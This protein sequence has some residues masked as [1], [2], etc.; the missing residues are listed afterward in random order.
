MN[1]S[2]GVICLG[3]EIKNIT[4]NPG[5]L[6]SVL[7]PSRVVNGYHALT[8]HYDLTELIKK[9]QDLQ[10]T[11]SQTLL[12]IQE[13]RSEFEN[14][15]LLRNTINATIHTIERKLNNVHLPLSTRPR[16]TKRGLING[17]GSIIKFVT[18]NLDA[19]DEERY[20]KIINQIQT[21]QQDLQSQVQLQYSINEATQQNFNKTMATIAH[22]N[23]E[24][25]NELAFWKTQNPKYSRLN[26]ARSILEHQ[27]M[28]FNFL[29][30][31][32]QDIESSIVACRTG[33]LH[34][35]VISA[36]TLY[37]ELS[38][39]SFFY[40]DRFPDFENQN[41]FEVQSYLKV[42]CYITAEEIIYF[43]DIP[44]M[45]PN[46]YN[47]Y[48]LEPLPTSVR[49]EFMTIIPDVKYFISSNKL[50]I[51][52][53][54]KCPQIGHVYLCPNYLLSASRPE[55]EINFLTNSDTSKCKFVK[56]S[57]NDNS[58]TLMLEINRYLLFFPRG[59]TISITQNEEIETRTLYGIYLASPGKQNLVYR[60]RTLFAP[61]NELA[62]KPFI[63][64]DVFPNLR[65]AQL[66]DRE[67]D[68]KELELNS[69]TLHDFRPIPSSGM[70]KFIQPSVWTILLYVLIVNL[71]LYITY[72]YFKAT[73]A[74]LNVT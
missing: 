12:N 74:V 20:D 71:M 40:K 37:Q 26:E 39:L 24:I 15:E 54:Q 14:T 3:S 61:R 58:V 13:D 18:G 51:P 44:L 55:C 50:A 68:L 32:I 64:G 16:K 73:R 34:P 57:T 9:T 7:G 62:G 47:M 8:H 6:S 69:L 4:T 52:L 42:K 11:Y 2:V 21:S 41:L 31:V 38:R 60:N 30:N 67:I 66:P 59:D 33:I 1:L 45:D 63:I 5:L 29:L 70:Q 23:Q 19:Q 49:G 27:Q 17:I 22:N 36:D 28:S 46:R 72:R 25:K 35:S 65:V 56:L 53:T 10:V 48:Y 43:L